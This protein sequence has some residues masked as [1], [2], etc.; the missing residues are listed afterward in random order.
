M[1][2]KN[3]ASFYIIGGGRAGASLTSYLIHLGC[4]I[5]SL[6]E[7][8]PE[9]LNFLKMDLGWKFASAHLDETKLKYADVC[10]LTLPDD[11]IQRM[12]NKLARLGCSWT[13]K[14]VAHCSG[15]LS[16]SILSSLKEQGAT[17]A[18]LH[19]VYSFSQDPRDNGCFSD[20]W[21]NV[22][23]DDAAQQVFVDLLENVGNKIVRVDK[24]QKEAIHLACVFYANFYV[25]LASMA[26]QIMNRFGYSEKQVLTML[27]PLL[28]SSI[29]QVL[30]YGCTAG[31]TGP[32]KR[33]DEDTLRT[34]LSYL[35]NHNP[36]LQKIYIQL[37]QELLKIGGLT[38]KNRAKI[39]KILQQYLSDMPA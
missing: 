25:A 36:E 9:R 30:K 22:E 10:L 2:S 31:L 20:I 4:L 3:K 24:E 33:V 37:S 6:V 8:D 16:T 18:S 11:H 29:E 13:N 35:K 38:K 7:Q 15:A 12:A 34:H 23:G 5:I 14:V 27:N 19:P 39:E 21:F 26:G 28:S 32:V 1:E 17:V